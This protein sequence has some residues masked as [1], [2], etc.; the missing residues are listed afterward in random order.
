MPKISLNDLHRFA[1][2]NVSVLWGDEKR[3][4]G[5][6]ARRLARLASRLE[7]DALEE[8]DR[9]N[10]ELP[11]VDRHRYFPADTPK[12]YE[13]DEAD[14]EF[15][16]RLAKE[17]FEKEEGLPPYFKNASTNWRIVSKAMEEIENSWSTTRGA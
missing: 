14:L 16:H 2:Y 4:G 6:H 1:I 3:A 8:F 15:L 10:R 17:Y 12:E 7:I 11:D 5:P 9:K 13:L